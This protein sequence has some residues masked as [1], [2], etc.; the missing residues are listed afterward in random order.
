MKI[1]KRRRREG[2]TDYKSRINL[3]KSNTPRIVIRR[4]NKYITIQYIESWEALDKTIVSVSSRDLLKNGWPKELSGSLKSIPA[5]YLTGYL[6]GKKI[7]SKKKKAE[8]IL[9]LGLNR[10]V[11]GSRLYAALNGLIDAG[12]E[13]PANEKVFPTKEKLEGSNVDKKVKEIVN[14]I[15][16]TIK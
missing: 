12:M 14:K 16:A 11:S 7:L 6:A 10:N 8:G 15:K 13:I 2:K 4:T 5:S 9:D 1:D 3:L